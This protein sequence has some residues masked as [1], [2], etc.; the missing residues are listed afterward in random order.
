VT[1]QKSSTVDT[2]HRYVTRRKCYESWMLLRSNSPV[3]FIPCML[4]IFAL[5]IVT[6]ACAS[7]WLDSYYG[8][9]I[10][11]TVAVPA[12]GEYQVELNPETVT[13]WI[14]E[15]SDFKIAP[16]FFAYDN[17]KLVEVDANGTAVNPDVDA[18]YR[19]HIG[20]DIVQNGR[21]E[22][23]LK[24]KPVGWILTNDAFKLEKTSHDGSLCMTVTG[25]DRSGCVQNISTSPHTLYRLSCMAKGPNAATAQMIRKGDRQWWQPLDH[26][27]S[28]PYAP[29]NAWHKVEYYFDTGDKSDWA[30]D[31]VQI[32]F[33][34]R[35]SSVDDV[36]VR[37]C[38]AAFTLKA[39][40]GGVMH[41]HLYYSP[42]EGVTPQAPGR[43]VASLPTRKLTVK[44]SGEVERLDDEMVYSL[45]SNELGDLWSAATTHK[46][47]EDARPPAGRRGRIE[48]S[49]AR[50]ESEAIQLVFR[51]R[52]QGEIT[53]VRV[54][55]VGP[56]GAK[57]DPEQF[58]IRRALYVSIKTPSSSTSVFATP[59]GSSFTGRLPDP[60]PKFA[61]VAFKPDDPN[62]LIWVDV[63]VPKT[64]AAGIYQ[65]HLELETSSGQ[66][67]VPMSLTVW[68]FTLP[69]RPTCRTAFQIARFANSFLFPFHKVTTKD[70]KQKLTRAYIAELARHK[71]SDTG[72]TTASIW[73]PATVPPSPCRNYELE[74]PWVIDELHL[75][76]FTIGHVGGPSLKNETLESARKTAK[77]YE[78]LAKCLAEKGWLKDAYIQIDEPQPPAFAGVR[79]W[80]DA[81]REQPNAKNIKMFGF[82]YNAEAWDDLRDHLDIVVPVN[83]DGANAFSQTAIARK[84][85]QQEAW[86]Y[87]TKTCHQW[88]D[89]PGIDQRL[90]APK[91][92]WMGATGMST[93]AVLIWWNESA[94]LSY[95]IDNPWIDPNSPW[96]NG[97]TAYFYPPN[98]K[99]VEL[100]EQDM[101]IIPSLRLIL[102]RDGI[103]DFEYATILEHL[104]TQAKSRGRNTM[105]A[106][107][108]IAQMR[109]QFATPVSWSMSES[110]WQEARQAVARAIEALNRDQAAQ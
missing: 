83:N 11:I 65:G 109:R 74:L 19:I 96:G 97:A 14:N 90:W 81:F 44:R 7:E 28:D 87:W 79:N 78:V 89:A 102:T 107:V 12:Q 5:S 100:A 54:N 49:C 22:Q 110:H 56:G 69:D 39:D 33:E 45:N 66:I 34:R 24:G 55:L 9:R 47:L 91:T 59:A 30:S 63:K 94:K 42:L 105:P 37:E 51:P 31:Q 108:A 6:P 41:Y 77:E 4:V 38:R 43:V 52:A 29:S 93:W 16:R 3:P 58:D 84:P 73:S 1:D 76:G 40:R 103:E 15:K 75:T 32:R 64:A 36:S 18:G 106:E 61:P 57:L 62:L 13:A 72:P 98:P 71:I 8:Y 48:F 80:I 50:N 10:P 60:L 20:R 23:M 27:Y 53:S 68:N 104:M 25:A 99:G 92:W 35:T 86:C 85:P 101:T 67:A 95:T 82:I 21:F 2:Q 46:V 26:T 17:V 88:I 70:D